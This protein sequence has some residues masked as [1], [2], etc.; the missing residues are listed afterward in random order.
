VAF[1]LGDTS[2]REQGPSLGRDALT[3][4]ELFLFDGFEAVAGQRLRAAQNSD[5]HSLGLKRSAPR[6]SSPAPA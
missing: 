1:D 4:D 2:H 6:C 3:D 5:R